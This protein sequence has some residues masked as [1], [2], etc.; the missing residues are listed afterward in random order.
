MTNLA[1]VDLGLKLA[2]EER[3]PADKPTHFPRFCMLVLV[4]V[5]EIVT[6]ERLRLKLVFRCLVTKKC[7]RCR[8][9]MVRLV[10]INADQPC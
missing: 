2:C 7:S 10:Y 8:D 3:L 9:T 6:L 5:Q 4:F 1:R